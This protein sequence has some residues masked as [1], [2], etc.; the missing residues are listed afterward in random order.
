MVNPC[1]EHLEHQSCRS[2]D[3]VAK[4]PPPPRRYRRG[5]SSHAVLLLLLG[6]LCVNKRMRQSH[7][8]ALLHA[9]LLNEPIPNRGYC[10]IRG[11]PPQ[12]VRLREYTRAHRLHG[13]HD[14]IVPKR[15]LNFRVSSLCNERQKK[16]SLLSCFRGV[17]Y[18]PIYTCQQTDTKKK[19]SPGMSTSR[20][21]RGWPRQH[22]RR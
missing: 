10:C 17:F 19:Q 13:F 7:L 20:A 22:R 12:K 14:N 4:K 16:S 15:V 8:L 2:R 1:I 11:K 18:T 3:D 21:P 6:A 9:A 5:S